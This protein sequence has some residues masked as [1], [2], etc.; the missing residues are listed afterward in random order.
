MAYVDYAYYKDTYGGTL[1]TADNAEKTLREASNTIDALTYCRIVSRGFEGLTDFQKSII[2]Q[3]VCALADWQLENADI[4]ST[5]YSNYSI[6][7]VSASWDNAKSVKNLG[8]LL[9]P[10]SIYAELLKTGLCYGG[11]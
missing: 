1:I 4:L 2:Q 9:I 3:V 7:G 5:P 6:N 10:A 11:V 8:G